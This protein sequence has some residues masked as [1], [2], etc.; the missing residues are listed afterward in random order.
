ME[1]MLNQTEL[2]TLLV[3]HLRRVYNNPKLVI[4]FTDST[5]IFGNVQPL[6]HETFTSLS[7]LALHV[8]EQEN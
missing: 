7:S 8:V 5:M 4:S 1:I 6:R 3:E 2:Q